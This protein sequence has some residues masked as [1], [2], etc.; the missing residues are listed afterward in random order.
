MKLILLTPKPVFSL[1]S[2]LHEYDR[3][4]ICQQ[5]P[6]DVIQPQA[7]NLSAQLVGSGLTERFG[8]EG[9]N[10]TCGGDLQEL[11]VQ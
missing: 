3:K 7:L 1:Y 4:C 8:S 10:V 11:Q 9:G 6:A 2:F 5:L